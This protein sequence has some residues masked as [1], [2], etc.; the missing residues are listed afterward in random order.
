LEGKF[1]DLVVY[2]YI[3]KSKYSV[4]FVTFLVNIVVDKLGVKVIFN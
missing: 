4:D 3:D 2:I 1:V